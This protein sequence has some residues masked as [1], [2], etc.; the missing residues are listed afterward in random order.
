MD[1]LEA[2]EPAAIVIHIYRRINAP[3]LGFSSNLLVS[4]PFGD[5]QIN[6]KVDDAEKCQ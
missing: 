2:S 5:P 4:V 3:C 1:R 6:E